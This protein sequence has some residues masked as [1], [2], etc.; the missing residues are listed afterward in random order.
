MDTGSRQLDKFVADEGWGGDVAVTGSMLHDCNWSGSGRSPQFTWDAD[1]DC[2]KPQERGKK[3]G[4]SA[5]AAHERT[6]AE[7]RYRGRVPCKNLRAVEEMPP[8]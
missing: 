7:A 2:W 3:P 5:N 6:L 4:S 1:E 8:R